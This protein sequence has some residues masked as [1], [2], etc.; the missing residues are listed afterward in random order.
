MTL[1]QRGERLARTMFT[2]GPVASFEAA[3]RLQLI[4]LLREGLYPASKVVDIGCGCLRGGYWLIHFL[5]EGC[6]FGV[7]PNVEM[8]EAGLREIVELPVLEEKGPRFDTN[9][10]F[11]VSVFGEKF[12]FFLARS[13]WTHASRE[14]IETMLD[15][16]LRCSADTGTFLTSYLRAGWLRNRAYTGKG[17]VGRSHKSN[18][19]GTIHHD[20]GWIQ[21]ACSRRGL[22]ARELDE[23]VLNKQIWLRVERS[24]AAG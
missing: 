21:E 8:L 10:E 6:Y 17:W 5:D 2:G 12:D 18:E 16:F 19:P 13:I 14:Q 11:D 23:D 4:T 1:Q 20:F 7:E 24:R 3:G 15:Q 22:V 9:G